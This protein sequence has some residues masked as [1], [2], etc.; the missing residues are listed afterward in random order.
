MHHAASTMTDRLK[1]LDV[2]ERVFTPDTDVDAGPSEETNDDL[3]NFNKES[4][5]IEKVFT[6]ANKNVQ[7]IESSL[8]DPAA[9]SGASV[10]L[11]AV[12]AKL[13][14]VRKRLQRMS[15][16]NKEMGKDA[17]S[18]PNM[19]RI[20]VA[21]CTKLAND[22]METVTGVQ[23]ARETHRSMSTQAVKN[24]IL[25]T[26]P[27][28]S[29]SEVQRAIDNEQLDSVLQTSNPQ[30]ASQLNEI[31]GRNRDIQ[32]LT[33]SITQ[34][35]QMFTDM[36]ILVQG[37]QGII[38][39][40]EHNV[41]DVKTETKQATKELEVALGYQRSARKKKICIAVIII[42]ILAL[43]IGGILI[44]GAANGW[45]SGG[46]SS[47]DDANT[48]PSPSISPASN[49]Q[50]RLLVDPVEVQQINLPP[51]DSN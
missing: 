24:D 12:D 22:F 26:N 48:N 42:V 31:R 1:E 36:S 49:Q 34:L 45:F 10:Q 7:V 20:R 29:E 17:S 2:Q 37:Q 15:A 39:K 9:L 30:L 28:L 32:K 16:E 50:A 14:N 44:Y 46:D 6:W 38:N 3:A 25:K 11:D 8:T 47:S 18:S 40:I 51:A 5:A 35:Q 23:K 43:I 27:N 41:A 21:R 19:M 13:D 33:K 4:E